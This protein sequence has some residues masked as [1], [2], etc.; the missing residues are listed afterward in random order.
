MELSQIL[1]YCDHTLLKQTATWEEIARV[2]DEAYE[3]NTASVCIPPHFVHKAEHYVG[4]QVKICT[5][6]GFP[7]GYN[8]MYAKEFETRAAVDDGAE[9]IDVVINIGALK[10]GSLDYVKKELELVRAACAEKLLKVIIETCLLTQEEKISMCKIVTDIGAD[11]IKT[12]TGFSSSGATF[13]D[14]ILF[15]QH[16]GSNVKIKA[17]GGIRTIEAAEKFLLL[18]AERLGTSALVEFAKNAKNQ[19]K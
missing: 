12:S 1:K 18:G 15:K 8:T 9:E 16:V 13:D 5:V 3:F 6:I 14:V 17:A 19:L 2:C 7:N 10:E 11:Y 4:D